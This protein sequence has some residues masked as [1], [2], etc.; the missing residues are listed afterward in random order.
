MVET[1]AAWDGT[2]FSAADDQRKDSLDLKAGDAGTARVGG[3][4]ARVLGVLGVWD[5]TAADADDAAEDDGAG[6]VRLDTNG[7]GG[8][9]T[10]VLETHGRTAVVA[11]DVA[12][13]DGA[14]LGRPDATRV[15][16]GTVLDVCG[17]TAVDVENVAEEEA[18]PVTLLDAAGL[19]FRNDLLAFVVTGVIGI[20]GGEL[21]RALARGGELSSESTRQDNH[22]SRVV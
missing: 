12:G 2:V 17:E 8:C 16:G 18:A 22:Y 13:G 6:P 14:G 3:C 10:R 19:I 4:T 7:V 1:V 5:G 15:G 11:D 20:S 9:T 21:S